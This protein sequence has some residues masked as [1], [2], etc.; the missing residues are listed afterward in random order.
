[1]STR[2]LNACGVERHR[3]AVQ[4]FCFLVSGLI[5]SAQS[6]QSADER[7]LKTKNRNLPYPQIA[8]ITQI[9]EK[10][11]KHEKDKTEPKPER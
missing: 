3:S 6:A 10:D 1:V 4:R 5:L 2:R 8:Q 9:T 7:V 11:N